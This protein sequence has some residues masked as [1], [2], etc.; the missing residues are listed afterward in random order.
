MKRNIICN[1]S[2]VGYGGGVEVETVFYGGKLHDIVLV[3]NTIA[4][5]KAKSGGGI[6]MVTMSYYTAY[7]EGKNNIVYGN[8]AKKDSEWFKDSKTTLELSYTC[9]SK[10]LSGTGNITS[11]PQFVNAASGDFHLKS[12]STCIDNGDPSSDKDPD[13]TRADMGALFYNQGTDI[14]KNEVVEMYD[15]KVKTDISNSSIVISYQLADP[16]NIKLDIVN[17]E[18]KKIYTL[19]NGRV[20]AG[21]Y[22]LTWEGRN[23]GGYKVSYGVYFFRFLVGNN[24]NI[25]K[26]TYVR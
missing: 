26:M 22:N 19:I 17:V 7:I 9:C 4:K 2:T 13:N 12:G 3:N 16:I 14:G 21:N 8:T 1:N 15:F 10:S 24:L 6:A 18:G 5:N 25:V 23:Y 20:T 11:D